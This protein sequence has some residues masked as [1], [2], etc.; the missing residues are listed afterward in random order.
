M[1][2][3]S[4]RSAMF[5][6]FLAGSYVISMSQIVH[7]ITLD[8]KQIV[9]INMPP[10]SLVS[11]TSTRSPPD[12]RIGRAASISRP[13][14]AALAGAQFIRTAPMPMELLQDRLNP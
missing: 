3:D 9:H 10:L 11:S 6:L 13:D 2:N 5:L 12:V 1:S 14:S 7:T 8:V 4:P